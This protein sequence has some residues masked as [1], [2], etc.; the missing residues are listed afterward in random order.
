MNERGR[1]SGEMKT[2]VGRGVEVC[3][4]S[5]KTGQGKRASGE[6]L[7]WVRKSGKRWGWVLR[8]RE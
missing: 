6:S 8:V 7:G 4:E 3:D 1:E 5:G 2:G